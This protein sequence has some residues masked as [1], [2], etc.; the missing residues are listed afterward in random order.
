VRSSRTASTK[1]QQGDNIP[2]TELVINR[3]NWIRGEGSCASF[4]LRPGD[5]MMCCLGFYSLACGYTKPQIE[6]EIRPDGLV[7]SHA[8]MEPLE[9]LR[10]LLK[11]V[12]GGLSYNTNETCDQLMSINDDDS[13]LKESREGRVAELFAQNGVKVTFTDEPLQ[14]A[15]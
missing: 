14:D 1:T 4:L 7:E 2:V 10:W 12:N 3:P 11:T 13:L 5:G 15:V 6:G 9:G 8:L